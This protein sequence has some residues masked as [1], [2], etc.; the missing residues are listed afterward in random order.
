LQKPVEAEG[1]PE[2]VPNDYPSTTK[3]RQLIQNPTPI[4]EPTQPSNM[5][6][7]TTPNGEDECKKMTSLTSLIN[8]LLQKCQTFMKPIRTEKY[9]RQGILEQ[10]LR[11]GTMAGQI[12]NGLRSDLARTFSVAPG[13][14]FCTRVR[15]FLQD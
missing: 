12:L 7:P 5:R 6:G 1:Q 3:W 15:E 4:E 10:H 11:F 8:H 13:N 2:P 9:D 14:K